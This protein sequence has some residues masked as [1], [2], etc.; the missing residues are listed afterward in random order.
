MSGAGQAGPA[1]LTLLTAAGNKA[2]KGVVYQRYDDHDAIEV[3]KVAAIPSD[4]TGVMG[5]PITF[6]GKHNPGQ[7]EIVGLG[8]F[9]LGGVNT[10]RRILIRHRA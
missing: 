5:V 7:F 1:P 4:H 2:A 8:Q 10:Y 6:A 3:P 9:K